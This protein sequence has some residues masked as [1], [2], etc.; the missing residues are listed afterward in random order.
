MECVTNEHAVAP[1]VSYTGH[2]MICFLN[3]DDF[4]NTWSAPKVMRIFFFLRSA[5]GPGK[6]S[7]GR[8]RRRGGGT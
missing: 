5:E 6:E 3:T 4:R 8:G 1:N 2:K 7:G